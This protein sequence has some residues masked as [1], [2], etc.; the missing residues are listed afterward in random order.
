MTCLS[1]YSCM[2]EQVVMHGSERED[3]ITDILSHALSY[4][5]NKNY[6]I[7]FH[8][9][10]FP[11]L[12]VLEIIAQNKGIDIIAGGATKARETMLK[13]IR[14]PLLKGLY[15]W[16]IA[17]VTLGNKE[18]FTKNSKLSEFKK[19]SAG[20]L[21]SWSDTKILESNDIYVEKGSDYDGLFDMLVNGRFDY[22]PRAVIEVDS[23]F[24]KHKDKNLVV[25]QKALIHYPTAYYFYVNKNN[26]SLAT[27]IKEGLERAIK[28]GSFDRLFNKY[29]GEI[30]S[31]IS[32]QNRHVYH[33]KNPF[34]SSKTPLNRAELWL[35]LAELQPN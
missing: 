5:P 31:K 1:S 34:L 23:E 4:F 26:V 35:D 22:F 30:V 24:D 25:E 7:N 6:K 21:H 28:D 16:R 29:Y 19:L 14:I 17:L 18:I 3:Y 11:K 2:A 27:N 13:P 8:N 10:S 9:K 12:R 15:G 33:L 20:Q 32:A